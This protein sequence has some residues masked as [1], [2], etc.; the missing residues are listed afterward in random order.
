MEGL[1]LSQAAVDLIINILNIVILFLIV[2]VL[3][4]KPVRNFLDARTKRV[5]DLQKK[6]ETALSEA[7]HQQEEYQ[8]L[9]AENEQQRAKLLAEA[10]QKAMENA[11]AILSDA[12][13]EAEE[14]KEK[15]LKKIDEEHHDMVTAMQDE[16]VDMA[17]NI[18]ERILKREVSEEDN[19][20]VIHDFF[21][22]RKGE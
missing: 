3:V 17:I 22:S 14:L 4:Y 18:S 16:I 19:K 8:R 6:A 5:D 15:A 13:K 10:E 11:E 1:V 7:E 9:S 21:E 2:R 12:Q 20:T